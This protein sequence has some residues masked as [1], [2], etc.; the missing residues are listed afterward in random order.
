M[1]SYIIKNYPQASL[2]RNSHSNLNNNNDHNIS[3]HEIN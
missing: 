1:I 3:K 2:M